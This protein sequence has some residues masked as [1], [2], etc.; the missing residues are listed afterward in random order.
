MDYLRDIADNS[1][2]AFLKLAL[3][4]PLG[5]HRRALPLDAW[6]IARVTAAFAEDCG[7]CAQIAITL[8]RRDHVSAAHLR[9]VISGDSAALPEPLRDV[10]CFAHTIANRRDDER[11]R[12]RLRARYGQTA[13][14]ELA[15][16]AAISRV[17][18]TLKRALGQARACSV[19]RFE[20]ADV[21]STPAPR[22]A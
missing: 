1:P 19:L 15:L 22:A 16:A 21:L 3:I 4:A 9:A 6:H 2:A 5:V 17:I 10:Y 13:L 14:V 18:P 12:E 11:L 20:F 8:A 7:T